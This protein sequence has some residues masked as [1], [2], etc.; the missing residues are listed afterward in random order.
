MQM[1]FVSERKNAQFPDLVDC[2]TYLQQ[3][4]G[5]FPSAQLGKY[6]SKGKRLEWGVGSGDTQG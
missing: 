6:P 5:I 3:L 1:Y 4:L 2:G